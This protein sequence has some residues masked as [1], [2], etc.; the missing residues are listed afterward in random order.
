MLK[1]MLLGLFFTALIVSCGSEQKRLHVFTWANYVGDEIRTGFE[2][3]FGVQV[4]VDVFASNEDLLAKLKSGASGYDVI[5]P[6]DFM[7]AIMIKENLLSALDLTKIPNFKNISTQFLNRDFDPENRYSVP[8]T[9]GL[10]ASHST[11]PLLTRRPTACLPC[12]TI[13]TV[14]S[15]AC[16]TINVK[17]SV[18]P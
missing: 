1:R 2:S 5:M 11:R 6:S 15:S 13:G 18:L 16:W 17:Q 4:S 9:W 12:G 3:E 10:P 8:Y 14:E 7:V